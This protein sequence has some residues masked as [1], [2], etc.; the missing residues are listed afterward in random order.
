MARRSALAILAAL[1]AMAARADDL[2]SAKAAMRLKDFE[3]AAVLLSEAASKRSAP[4]QYLLATLYQSGLGVSADAAKARSLFESAAL[5]G[6]PRAAF[7]LASMLANEDPRDPNAARKWLDRAAELRFAPAVELQKRNALPLTSAQHVT[8]EAARREVFWNAA[9]KDNVEALQAIGAQALV[10]EADE[11]GRTALHRAA[12]A[13]AANAVA[14][15][16]EH[17]ARVDAADRF[18]VTPLMLA[19]GVD[20]AAALQSLLKSGARVDAKDQVGNAALAYAARHNRVAQ[21]NALLASGAELQAKS[22]NNWS[23][24]DYA[25]QADAKQAADALRARGATP[26]RSVANTSVARP[27]E[28]LRAPSNI[29][30]L[31]SGWSDAAVAA[32]RDDPARLR[33]VLNRAGAIQEPLLVLATATKSSNNIGVLA[34]DSQSEKAH[35]GTALAIAVRHGDLLAVRALLASGVRPGRHTQDGPTP[36]AIALRGGHT[37]V[38]LELLKAGA[39]VNITE[40][41]GITPLMLAAQRGQSQLIDALLA[42]GAKVDAIDANA[43]TALWYAA[44]AGH[45]DTVSALLRARASVEAADTLGVTPL[46]QASARGHVVSVDRLI[47]AGANAD[48]KTQRGDTALMLAAAAGHVDAVR[49]LL[50]AKPAL[51]AQNSS[52]DTA[53]IAASRAGHDQVVAALLQ[54]GASSKLRNVEKVSAEDVARARGFEPLAES[55]RRR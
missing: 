8:D 51:D 17:G 44:G 4:A 45:A 13:G 6:E 43:R 20:S 22:K 54:A 23:A 3:A 49:R 27:A 55:I 53:L 35:D 7:A 25:L 32:T 52:G 2:E 10:N 47:A 46:L 40:K 1:L 16:I 11:F 41:D 9:A 50:T 15:L 18:G 38:A 28:I 48:A 29:P 30:D 14:W 24:L 34:G 19:A 12:Q 33:E 21:L 39:D 42:A 31:Y 36:L 26:V 37:A 5:Q